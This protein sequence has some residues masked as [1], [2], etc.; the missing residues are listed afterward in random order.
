MTQKEIINE[1]GEIPT[2]SNRR[3]TVFDFIAALN[4]PDSK[5]QLYDEW[6][7]SKEV[8]EIVMYIQNN[9][10]ELSKMVDEKTPS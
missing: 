8:S 9:K 10:D 6:V 3:I 5:I 7:F 2:I 1:S 4:T